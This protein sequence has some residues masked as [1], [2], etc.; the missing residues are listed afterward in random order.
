MKVI[1]LFS[2]CGGFSVGFSEAG[3]EITKAVEF[4]KQIAESYEH[5][6]PGTEMICDD[7]KN[8]DNRGVF[9]QGE[10]DVIIGGPPCQGFSMAGARIRGHSQLLDDPRNYLFKHYYNV[11]N[12]VK[13]E[14]FVFENVKGILT[15]DHGLIFKEIQDLFGSVDDKTGDRYFVHYQIVNAVNYGVPQERERVIVMGLLNRDFDMDS[16]F[17]KTREMIASTDPQFFDK[18]TV[19]DAISDLG[20]PTDDGIVQPHCPLTNYQR[21]LGADESPITN[22]NGTKHNDVA[23]ERMKKIGS[24]ENYTKLDENIKSVHSGSYGRMDK[25]SPSRTITTRFDTPSGGMFIH[26]ADNRTITPREAA[27]IQSFPDSYVFTGTKTS[28]HKQIGNAVP[29]K[30]AYFLAMATRCLLN[31]CSGG[32][33]T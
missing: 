2:G 23:I 25:D 21:Y 27:R 9:K 6:H 26:P 12:A 3:F 8:V 10:A 33:E 4:D 19:W 13:P 18:V 20:K 16:L 29:P 28:I 17:D 22:H 15:K 14:C 32:K 31:D 24:G 11:V 5:N 30:V 7:I 1:D